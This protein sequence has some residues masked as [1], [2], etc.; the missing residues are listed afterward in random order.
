MEQVEKVQATNHLVE[1]VNNLR[2]LA[3]PGGAAWELKHPLFLRIICISNNFVEIFSIWLIIQ[4][5]LLEN[6]E[7]LLI[8]FEW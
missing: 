1:K 8:T 3:Y 7:N 4:N 5:H 6:Q 2:L